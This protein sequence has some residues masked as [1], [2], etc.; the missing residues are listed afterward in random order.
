M[1]NELSLPVPTPPKCL[2]T[3]NTKASINRTITKQ[4][5]IS[6]NVKKAIANTTAEDLAV[7]GLATDVEPFKFANQTP[8]R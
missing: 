4:T 2:S 8:L 3:A 7:K 1:S 5:Q 6:I